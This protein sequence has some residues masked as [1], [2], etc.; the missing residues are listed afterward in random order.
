MQ[1]STPF[2]SPARRYAPAAPVREGDIRRVEALLGLEAESRVALVISTT[3]DEPHCSEIML[4]H[5]HVEMATTDDVILCPSEARLDQQKSP[6]HSL[7]VQTR[8]RGTV[9]NLQLTTLL[10][11]LTPRALTK[12]ATFAGSQHSDSPNVRTG[13]PLAD[14]DHARITFQESE[15]HGL[16]N[17]TSDYTDALL[18]D[19]KPWQID[20]DLLTPSLLAK[21]ENPETILAET[22][23]I[24]RT[25]DLVVSVA[26]LHAL[27]RAGVFQPSTWKRTTYG[28]DIASQIATSTRAFAEL[29]LGTLS[30]KDK[31][32]STTPDLIR[33]R[34]R[35]SGTRDLL[36]R[37]YSRLVTAPFLW[38]DGGDRL[39]NSDLSSSHGLEILMLATWACS[40]Q[41][42]EE[43]YGF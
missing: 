43:I 20:T 18:D 21:S 7:V 3:V 1:A 36:L 16:L 35:I 6:L 42:T 24:M 11:Q 37:P 15:L 22:I 39:L 33:M 40:E 17:L 41:I 38:T 8:L 27:Q 26:D 31:C 32:S 5:E 28:R 12:I 10:D 2:L 4:I 23:H 30:Y 13:K 19:G 25:R 9:W 29:G 14:T 34:D